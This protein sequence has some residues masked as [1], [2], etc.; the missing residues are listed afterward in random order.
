[1]HDVSDENTVHN[2]SSHNTPSCFRNIHIPWDYMAQ[3]KVGSRTSVVM[4][5][6]IWALPYII[7]LRVWKGALV[8]S[9]PAY[10]LITVLL[11]Y[12]FCHAIV[13]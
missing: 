11:G 13:V 4:L 1:M 10:A 9:W 5:Q 7:T 12:P 6:L 3:R 2:Q 8:K